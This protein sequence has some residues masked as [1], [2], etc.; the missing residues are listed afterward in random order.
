M[1][2]ITKIVKNNFGVTRERD[3]PKNMVA[4]RQGFVD[5]DDSSTDPRG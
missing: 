3:Q 2:E 4:L 1:C 5:S